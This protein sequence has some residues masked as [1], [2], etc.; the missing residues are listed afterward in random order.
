MSLSAGG[1][2]VILLALA[3]ANLPFLNQRV[4]AVIPLGRPVKPI[5]L[6]LLEMVV[7]YFIVGF[8]AWAIESRI[9]NV[10][11]QGWEFYAVTASLFVVFAYPGFVYRYLWHSH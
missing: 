2:F 3:G 9:G 11:Q 5:W 7:T 6:R 10:F 4:F 1:W 8:L